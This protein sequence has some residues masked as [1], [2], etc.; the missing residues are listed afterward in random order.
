[1]SVINASQA[2]VITFKMRD[3][4]TVSFTPFAFSSTVH[5]LRLSLQLTTLAFFLFAKA[6]TFATLNAKGTVFLR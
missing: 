3:R 5:L 2:N 4:G 1:M 6:Y